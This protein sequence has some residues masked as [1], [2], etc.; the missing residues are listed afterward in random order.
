MEHSPKFAKTGTAM[1]TG[2]NLCASSGS[3]TISNNMLINEFGQ[4]Q[5]LLQSDNTDTTNN[6]LRQI[7]TSFTFSQIYTVKLL[8]VIKQRIHYWRPTT[9]FCLCLNGLFFQKLF[10]VTPG[11]P[12]ANGFF[13]S[14]VNK[15]RAS[16]AAAPPPVI[17]D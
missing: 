4:Q 6:R 2:D 14:K 16:T 1:Y 13:H 12:K 9:S 8:P 15:I 17:T 3:I 10:Q 11:C 5:Q 7:A